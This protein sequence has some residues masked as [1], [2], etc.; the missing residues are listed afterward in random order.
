ML[1]NE[2]VFVF[3]G[4]PV[5]LVCVIA[6]GFVLIIRF[7][8]ET[9]YSRRLLEVFV[10][11]VTV[12][13]LFLFTLIASWCVCVFWGCETFLWVK[14]G[15][16]TVLFSGTVLFGWCVYRGIFGWRS[17]NPV[18][19]EVAVSEPDV[20]LPL[21]KEENMEERI[22]RQLILLFEEKK[23]Y[24]EFELKIEDVAMRIGTNRTY[25]SNVLNKICGCHFQ[26]Y[27]NRYRLEEAQK[28][29]LETD[30]PMKKIAEMVGF[31]SISTFNCQFR[32]YSKCSPT[33]W[34]V[35]F[36]KME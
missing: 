26:Y 35:M 9:H 19:G 3:A 16:M 34:K 32:I 17:G 13:Y 15:I 18:A 31:N 6:L 12:L 5:L 20:V 28:L 4:I 29:I 14:A 33:E 30:K 27:V 24:R 23:I 1:R 25:V 22:L 36:R 10:F 2:I 11:C 21:I 8:Q 7:R